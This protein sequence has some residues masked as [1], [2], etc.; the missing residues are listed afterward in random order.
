LSVLEISEDRR[1]MEGYLDSRVCHEAGVENNKADD[2]NCVPL[3]NGHERENNL[4]NPLIR[5]PVDTG[6][7]K[8]RI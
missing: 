3:S 8:A 7:Y 4:K 5:L 2:L 1:V 6:T